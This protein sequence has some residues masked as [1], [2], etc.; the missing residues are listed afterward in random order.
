MHVANSSNAGRSHPAASPQQSP[1]IDNGNALMVSNYD[2][3]ILEGADDIG[4]P[5]GLSGGAKL[6]SPL[7]AGESRLIRETNDE[8]SKDI[9]S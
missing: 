3:I 2:E 9:G 7:G 4:G 1:L 8:A 5:C 6:F